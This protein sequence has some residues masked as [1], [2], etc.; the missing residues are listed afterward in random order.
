MIVYVKNKLISMSGKSYVYDENKNHVFK[1]KGSVFSL[2][3]KK[4]IC[5][6]DGK[7]LYV[8][9][10]RLINWWMPKAMIYDA[11]GNKIATVRVAFK[12]FVVDD[13]KE[14]I[15]VESNFF[16][17][18]ATI[19]RNGQPIGT[20]KREFFALA[21]SFQIEA[22]EADIPFLVTLVIAIDNI[23]DKIQK[24]TCST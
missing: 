20:V 19:T 17:L 10:N 23:Q 9:K 11:D 24:D 13:Y 22:E 12:K 4:T 7:K 3:R 16:K 2:R 1:V 18:T 21:D 5:D 6:L 14:Q 15:Q 8:V